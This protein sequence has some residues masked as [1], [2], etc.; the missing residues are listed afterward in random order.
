MT[1]DSDI[2]YQKQFTYK[3]IDDSV[4]PLSYKGSRV[5]LRRIRKLTNPVLKKGLKF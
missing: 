2:K 4:S 3:Y 1:K 5:F